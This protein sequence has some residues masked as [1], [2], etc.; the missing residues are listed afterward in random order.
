MIHPNSIL[1]DL[2][3]WKKVSVFMA[4]I[5]QSAKIYIYEYGFQNQL[6][7]IEF[8]HQNPISEIS[9]NLT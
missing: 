2:S 1:I 8:L 3:Q 6:H 7:I 4:K 9:L 5:Y